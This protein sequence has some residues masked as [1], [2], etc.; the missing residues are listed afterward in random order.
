[1][2]EGPAARR[3]PRALPDPRQ[4]RVVGQGL[5]QAIAAEPADR[6]IDLRLAHQPPVMDD[7]QKEAGQHEP[8][9]NLGIDARTADLGVVQLGQLT[10]KPTQVEDPIDADQNMIMGQHITQRPGYE[11][12]R[13]PPFLAPQHPTSPALSLNRS[14]HDQPSFSTAPRGSSATWR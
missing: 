8:H 4:R 2:P 11:Q 5:V 12:F 13:L 3:P 1:M 14:N 7:A 10:S 6:Q 9:R